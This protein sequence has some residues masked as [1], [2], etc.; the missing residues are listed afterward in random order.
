MASIQSEEVAAILAVDPDAAA[1]RDVAD[2]R[3]RRHRPA[4]AG[5]VAQQVADAADGRGVGRI[6]ATTWSARTNPL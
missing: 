4:A 1:L 5:E 6:L 2:D 3:L